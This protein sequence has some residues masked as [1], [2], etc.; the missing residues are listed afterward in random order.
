MYSIPEEYNAS[1]YLQVCKTIHI[2]SLLTCAYVSPDRRQD[3]WSEVLTQSLRSITL[4]LGIASE[5]Q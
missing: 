4:G 1:I 5:P 3:L 2:F